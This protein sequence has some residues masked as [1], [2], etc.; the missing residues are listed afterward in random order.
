MLRY[1]KTRSGTFAPKFQQFVAGDFVYLKRKKADSLDPR[2]G[3]LVLRVKSVG[4]GSRL[5]LEGRD[6]KTV[7][8]HVENCAPCHLPNLDIWQ[9]PEVSAWGCRHSCQ[10]CHQTTGGATMLLC[11]GC[12]NGWHRASLYPPLPATPLGNWFYPKCSQ[13]V[14][15]LAQT[16]FVAS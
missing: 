6:K 7:R 14:Q 12:N 2:V 13:G 10:V 8:D 16:A 4:S 1:T 9:K 5:V 3:R 15:D 11:D